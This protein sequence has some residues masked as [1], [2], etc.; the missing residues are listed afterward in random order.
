[1][2]GRLLSLGRVRGLV[3]PSILLTF[4]SCAPG[5]EGGPG[6][7]APTWT[8]ASPDVRIGS[9]TDPDYSFDFVRDLA[10]SP[11]GVLHSIHNNEAS[12]RRW[13]PEGTPAGVVG[14]AG[15][16]PGEFSRPQILGFFGDSLWVMDTGAYRISYFD[17]DGSFLGSLTPTVDMSRDPD[18]PYASAARPVRPLRDGT[19]Y[20]S[21]PAWSREIATGDITETRHAW[22]DAEGQ[23]LGTVWVQ[24][25]RT[26]DVRALLREGRGGSFMPQPFGDRPLTGF[27]PDGSLLVLNRRIPSGDAPA[28]VTVARIAMTGDTL[29][30]FHVP[31]TPVVLP[32]EAVDSSV[33]EVVGS[34]A[35]L[36][37]RMNFG[38]SLAELEEA[39]RAATFVPD[40]YPGVGKMVVADDGNIWLQHPVPVG[41]DHEW[42]VYSHEGDWLARVHIPGDLNVMLITHDAVW[43]VETDDLDVNYIVRYGVVKTD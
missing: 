38:M 32:V 28:Q 8:L 30:T 13:T 4:S 18:N 31:Y 29:S 5:T 6:M 40:H 3:L 33:Q 23:E 42:R 25:Y 15:E 12:V 19:L 16:G 7:E 17:L 2:N 1:M 39:L 11:T 24:D 27:P 10:M 35:E 34:L 26:T 9:P 37:E 21:A 20:G 22:M 14:R 36:Y 43:G 41:G